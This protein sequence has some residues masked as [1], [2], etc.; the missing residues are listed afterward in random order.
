[1]K[2]CSLQPLLATVIALALLLSAPGHGSPGDD[3]RHLTQRDGRQ[4]EILI[5]PQFTADMQDKL[6]V[7]IE[8]ISD[9]LHQVYGHWPARHWQISVAPTAASSSDPIPWAQV[10]RGAVNRVEFFTSADASSEE[11]QRAWTGY[12]ELAHLLIPY[13][14]WGDAWFSEGLASYYQNIL[15]AR[16]GLISEREMWQKLYDGFQRG[17]AETRFD[18][19]T[20]R[21]VS[22]SLRKNGGF[23]RVYWS[24]ASYFLTADSR[25]RLQSGGALNLDKAL[26][27]LNDCC[28]DQSLSVPQM[29]ARLDQLNR[30]LLFGILYDEFA[31]ST[32]VPA[33]DTIFAS[34][35]IDVVDGAV[36]LQE[37]G[38]GARLRRE[39]VEG[40]GREVEPG[41]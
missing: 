1:V 22:D 25:L 10:H 31:T 39:I 19:E 26:E 17:L 12:H 38:P 16:M 41:L 37:T 32:T 23:M 34:L 5:S 33:F 3:N 2:A 24:G 27:K 4:L 36:Q 29:V 30:V 20:L 21:S 40:S 15:Q 14:G 8:Y 9:A 18:G 11:L 28:A 35:G 7:W 6:L 13:R